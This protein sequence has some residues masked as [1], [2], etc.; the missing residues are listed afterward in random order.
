[1]QKQ[2]PLDIYNNA[3]LQVTSIIYRELENYD[4]IFSLH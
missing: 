3:V 4:N 1:M 2:C